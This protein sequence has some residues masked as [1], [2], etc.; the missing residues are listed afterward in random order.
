MSLLN[1]LTDEILCNEL[2]SLSEIWEGC[3]ESDEYDFIARCNLIKRYPE[4]DWRNPEHENMLLEMSLDSH[5][6]KWKPEFAE[7]GWTRDDFCL[8][9]LRD[10]FS[11]YRMYS[12]IIDAARRT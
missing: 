10:L 12:D 6:R 11:Y 9:G 3:Y 7:G 2:N 8:D 4:I 5:A 1:R